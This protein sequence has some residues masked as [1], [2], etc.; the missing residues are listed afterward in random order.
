M[1]RE[2][3]LERAKKC[4][5]QNRE[6]EYGSP[7]DSFDSIARLWSAYKDV[8]FTAKDVAM[9]M[10]LLK[11][12]R[13]KTGTGTEDS[14]VDLAGYAACGAEITTKSKERKKV[15]YTP[16]SNRRGLLDSGEYEQPVFASSEEAK[17][18]ENAL[19]EIVSKYGCVSVGDLYDLSGLTGS[20][21]D[22]QYGW[23]DVGSS[24]VDQVL[25][26]FVIRLPKPVEFKQESK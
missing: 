25:N 2:E 16:V 1:T 10:A 3:T 5:C 21:I 18:V 4:V 17:K 9:M 15:Q 23:T 22:L 6:T 7:E 12:A 14:F 8:E 24:I 11:I 19:R 26:G 20:Y 13:V